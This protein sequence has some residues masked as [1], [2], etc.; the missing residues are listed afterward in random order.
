M[1]YKI[2]ELNKSEKEVEVTLPYDEIKKEIENEVLKQTKKIQMPGFRKGKVPLNMIKKMYGDA[3]EYEA[4]EKVANSRFWD[5]AKEKELNPI[6]Q[7]QMTDIKFTPGED[8]SFKVKFEILPELEVKDYKNLE[9]ELPEFMVKDEEVEHEIEHIIKANAATEE[10][11]MVGDDKNYLLNIEVHRVD[12]NGNELGDS[13]P[14]TLDVDLSN[15]RV[16]SEILENSKG[17][18]AGDF[19]SFTFKDEHTHKHDDKEEVHVEHYHYKA[20]INSVKKINLPELNEELIKKVTKDKISTVEEFRD[21][22][23]KD[24]QAYYDQRVDELLRDKLLHK[25]VEN[26]DFVPPRIM[27]KNVLE[28]LV[29]QEE[30]SM[31]KSGYKKFNRE[32]AEK[33]LEKS[34]ELEVKWFL[35][36]RAI[37]KQENITVSEESLKELAKKDAEK[38]G[39][40]EDKLIN[41]YKSSNINEKLL[42]KKL[43]DFLREQSEIKKVNPENLINKEAEETK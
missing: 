3:L 19:F 22:I 31:K 34:A 2:N 39:L 10:A 42:D 41:Y 4:S 18:K 24:M 32:E 30:E 21:G 36:K 29:K 5:V 37:E 12:E 33:R 20:K 13:K 9:I 28:D 23:K 6:G 25:I 7:P 16:N 17:K 1:E 38:T 43:F 15:E 27:V 8:L 35:I 11:D 14:E 40:P 26:N